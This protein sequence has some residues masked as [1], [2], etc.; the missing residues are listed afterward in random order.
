MWG[1]FKN[2]SPKLGELPWMKR[3]PREAMK[4]TSRI[5]HHT[6]P[7]KL[8]SL[9]PVAGEELNNQL[10]QQSAEK[11]AEPSPPPAVTIPLD[12]VDPKYRLF[13]SE[14]GAP[15]QPDLP[16]L[17][18][19]S[20]AAVNAPAPPMR[21]TPPPIIPLVAPAPTSGPKPGLPPLGTRKIEPSK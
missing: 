6:T 10:Y 14:L 2:R 12:R 19:A 1:D 3:D 11:G 13:D 8:P 16:G 21:A 9:K 17:S 20:D 18:N 4:L 15:T 7:V 5:S